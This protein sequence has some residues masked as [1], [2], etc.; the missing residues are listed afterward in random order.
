MSDVATSQCP[1][2]GGPLTFYPES[3]SFH[4]D[5]C[6]SIFQEDQMKEL[7]E[8]QS[9][10]SETIDTTSFN[11]YACPSCGGEIVTD[12]T[13]AA[14]FCYYCH[15]PV[16]LTERIAGDFTPQGI[17]PFQI[18]E[19]KAKNS[20]I[21]W[22]KKKFFAPKDFFSE[23]QIEKISGVYFPFWHADATVDASVTASGTKID[24]W[25][26]GDVEYTRT[27]RYRIFREGSI[28][29]KSMLKNALKKNAKQHM[30]DSIQPFPFEKVQPFDK[31]YFAGFQAEKRDIPIADLEE[32]YKSDMKEYATSLL[33][34]DM[35]GY[36]TVNPKSSSLAIK[37]QI[38]KY[39]L[40][41]L[42]VITYTN[43]DDKETPYFYAMNG[44]TG[45]TSGVLPLNQPK[46]VSV[47]LLIGLILGLIV[48]LGG[49]WLF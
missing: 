31:M 25:R 36:T 49:Y 37:E 19:K 22:G 28:R 26:V 40:L 18:D 30:I 42:W 8:Q 44:V 32:E 45:K 34:Q 48:L 39:Y 1:N 13:T 27:R 33:Q 5:Y 6:L 43:I 9:A 7:S 16:V 23:N 21:E 29:F 14:T 10:T 47:S 24:V 4:C 15:N 35:T 12:D 11:L 20:F 38:N 46:L 17:I 3:Q 41:P 2:C